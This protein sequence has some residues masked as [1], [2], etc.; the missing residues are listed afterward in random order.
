MFAN[1]RTERN[2]TRPHIT[3]LLI[4]D[5]DAKPKLFV[6]MTVRPSVCM[7]VRPKDFCTIKL[8]NGQR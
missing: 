8:E 6:K 4:L 3:T 2:K 1:N 7:S 5:Q